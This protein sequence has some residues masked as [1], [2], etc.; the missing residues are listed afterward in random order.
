MIRFAVVL[1]ACL[2]LT[3]WGFPAGAYGVLVGAKV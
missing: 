3:G 2:L 1:G